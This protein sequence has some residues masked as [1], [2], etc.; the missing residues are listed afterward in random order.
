MSQDIVIPIF[1][2]ILFL[3]QVYFYAMIVYFFMSWIPGAQQS[4]F[5]RILARIVEPYL[6]L[7]RRYI[8]PVGMFDLSAI[9]ALV[10]FNLF[11]NGVIAIY[12]QFVLPH[13]Y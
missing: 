11:R 5:G 3:L 8:P 4:A 12:Y 13:L 1:N 6:E 2:F 9:V 7:F 10:V